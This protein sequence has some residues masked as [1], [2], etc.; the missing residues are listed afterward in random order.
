LIAPRRE[1]GKA[2]WTRPPRPGRAA[3]ALRALFALL[4]LGVLT[5]CASAPAGP[6]HDGAD[7]RRLIIVAIRDAGEPVPVPGA[8]PRADYRHGAGYGGGTQ[9]AALAAELAARNGLQ[10]QAAWT[11]EPLHWR[12]MLYRIAPDAEPQAVLA[13]LA[14]DPRV[15]L[16]QPLN[17]Y[18]TLATVYDDPYIGLQRG[19]AAMDAAG[20]QQWTQGDGVRVA[21]IDSGVDGRHPELAGQLIAQ[22]D[23]VRTPPAD[24]GGEAHGTAMAGVIAAR[25]HNGIGIAGIAPHVGLLAY[26]ACWGVAEPP[27]ASRCDSFTLAQALGAAIAAR[28]DVINLSLGG[29]ADALLERLVRHAIDQGAIVV[30][31]LP[32][33]GRREGFPAGVSGVLVVASAEGEGPRAGVVSAPGRE[34]LTLAPGGHYDY[35]SGSSLAAA[36]VSGAVAL[37]RALDPGVRGATAQG[38]LEHGP[39]GAVRL[40]ADACAAVQ[41]LRPAAR[42]GADAAPR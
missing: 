17:S 1:N 19:F 40:S 2:R 32:R 6:A 10:E 38:W 34:I 7:G 27:G 28:A 4:L 9:A 37:L 15:Q 42:C 31:A 11:I 22:R 35:A 25:A 41:Q 5:A 30:G 18:E 29:P 16:A 13:A 39:A 23:F 36:H 33:S 20:A 12:C 24:A 14:A 8:T 21:L 26:R 3:G